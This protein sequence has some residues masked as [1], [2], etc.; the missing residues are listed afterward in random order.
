[1]GRTGLV[2]GVEDQHGA[3]PRLRPASLVSHPPDT[4]EP[5]ATVAVAHPRDATTL[6]D[7]S[8][9]PPR[10]PAPVAPAMGIN[11]KA[12]ATTTRLLAQAWRHPG[13]V[14]AARSEQPKDSRG[15]DG[16]AEVCPQ[17]GDQT[18][19]TAAPG[20]ADMEGEAHSRQ[21]GAP[22]ATAAE[23]LRR[24]HASAVTDR[25]RSVASNGL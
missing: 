17:P 8:G 25:D 19:G 20:Y 22:A 2:R 21:A 15:R 4:G 14:D 5:K 16:A 7:D 11:G 1:M 10:M 13:R 24:T 9:A 12:T 3:S 23:N 18:P 6:Q